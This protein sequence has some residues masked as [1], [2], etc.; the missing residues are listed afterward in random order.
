AHPKIFIFAAEVHYGKRKKKTR[1]PLDLEKLEVARREADLVRIAEIF[2]LRHAGRDDRASLLLAIEWLLTL[3]LEQTRPKLN[4]KERQIRAHR[5]VFWAEPFPAEKEKP[6]ILG[7]SPLLAF[8]NSEQ[9]KQLQQVHRIDI[10][11]LQHEAEQLY[12][13]LKE[14]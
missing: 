5:E 2:S 4:L 8:L 14:L 6:M 10:A 7:V 3:S 12:R 1:F 13:E 9:R 11:G